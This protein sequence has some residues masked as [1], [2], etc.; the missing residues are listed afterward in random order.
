MAI[1]S[2]GDGNPQ[3]QHADETKVPK[4]R[5]KRQRQRAQRGEAIHR[6]VWLQTVIRSYNSALRLAHATYVRCPIDY[7]V[8]WQG[9]WKPPAREQ[10]FQADHLYNLVLEPGEASDRNQ[11]S[12]DNN[13]KKQWNTSA[14][15]G[16][17][18]AV[19]KLV[20]HL[21]A[22]GGSLMAEASGQLWNLVLAK[23][24][25]KFRTCKLSDFEKLPWSKVGLPPPVEALLLKPV[26][27]T[28]R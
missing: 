24:D 27:A 20:T 9:V 28:G 21:G 2:C 3:E 25:V 17:K 19:E 4:S 6:E 23:Q 10:Y 14:K 16:D 15:E 22:I 18:K 26:K 11:V 1:H 7:Y 13:N 5:E 12:L 8:E